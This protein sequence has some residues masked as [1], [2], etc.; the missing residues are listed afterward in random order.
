MVCQLTESDYPVTK[1]LCSFLDEKRKPAAVRLAKEDVLA[2]ITAKNDVINCAGI[3]Y[4]RFMW[5][6]NKNSIYLPTC[7]LSG[8]TRRHAKSNSEQFP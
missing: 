3:M 2:G 1:P 4:A 7:N 6:V 8:L 5:H